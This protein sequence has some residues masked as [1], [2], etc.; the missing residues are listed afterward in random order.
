M[1]T[2]TPLTRR[3]T[4][5]RRRSIGPN[6]LLRLT[7]SLS[8]ALG[9]SWIGAAQ[10]ATDDAAL[11][12]SGAALRVAQ[13]AYSEYS[14]HQYARC[15][16]DARE[17]IRQRPDVLR[18]RLLLADALEVNG[19]RVQARRALTDAIVHLGP[20]AS[21]VKRRK[22][23][24][25]L[26][27]THAAAPAD[28]TELAGPAFDFAKQAYAAYEK[29]DFKG[30]VAAVTQAIALRP[31]VARLR[32][33][34]ID[35]LGAAG[36]DAQA[37]QADRDA[38]Q[39]LGDSDDLR[40]RRVFIG[41][42]LAPTLS[43][44][45]LQARERGDLSAALD[46]AGQAVA[47]AP[48]D[49]ISYRLQLMQI[50][51]DQRALAQIETQASQA[52]A[53]DDTQI[54]AWVLRG[55]ARAARGAS[56][57]SESDFAQALKI[58]D[59]N[60]IDRRLARI[61]IADIWLAQHQPQR[62]IDLL[63]PLKPVG[64][65]ADPM[66][67]DRLHQ[68]RVQLADGKSAPAPASGIAVVLPAPQIMC[69]PDVTGAACQTYPA[70]PGLAAQQ[71][72][73]AALQHN[74]IK[75]A[76]VAAQA[77]V[78]A[79]PE[80]PQHRVDL[81]NTLTGAND[82]AGAT[83][84]ARQAIDDGML[85]GM[86]DVSAAYIAARAGDDRVAV[87][88]FQRAEEQGTLPASAQADVAFA[89]IQA[90]QNQL[91][92]TYLEHAIDTGLAPPD[93]TPAAT[94]TQLLDERN[95]HADVTRNW[96]F[97]STLAYRGQQVQPGLGAPPTQGNPSNNNYQLSNEIYWRPL[98]SL[99]DRMLE[100]YAR[101]SESFGVPDGPS[102]VATNE[103]A[104]GVRAKPFKTINAIFAVEHILPLGSS[105][106]SDWLGRAAYSYGI[107]TERRLDVPSWWTVNAYG[108]IG[109]YMMHPST[110]GTAFVEAGRSYR[111]DSIS[112]RLVVFPFAVAGVDYDS[113][114]NHS[115]PLAAGVGVDTRYYFREDKYDSPRSYVDLT[116][117]Y[118]AHL[119]G[120]VR[121]RG[122]FAA[123]TFSY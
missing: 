108:E 39:R 37:F 118:R 85:D 107:G 121:G 114:I 60:L 100:V 115:L 102:G 28:G 97:T 116:V 65:E 10:A 26:L 98:G 120:D 67:P 53:Q 1:N 42:R 41:T 18:L 11:P 90:H 33:L 22:Q 105:A 106:R 56:A 86:S 71:Q 2:N 50:L 79:A 48:P 43:A 46:L 63:T 7:L 51:L 6:A 117:Q 101:D 45:A 75:A 31:D 14:L 54:M 74:D 104:L 111:V 15:A 112:P 76:L 68:A 52:I 30:A 80:V 93:G 9:L 83:R 123:T 89:A 21:L 69:D 78:A 3:T 84:A 16:V 66:L 4:P 58:E 8:L 57:D 113:T 96:G 119:V 23:I 72:V 35:A 88:R 103:I 44:Q 17:A 110:Y 99:N 59:A 5:P 36:Q 62:A 13:R 94:P 19:E 12:L 49:R 29:K 87:T 109:H 91:A 61:I 81:I 92:A 25:A 64:D 40:L 32:L 73:Y 77:A 38:Q 27:H 47:Y 95:A 24:D 82:E 70:D 34:Q 122:F 55:Y 20:E